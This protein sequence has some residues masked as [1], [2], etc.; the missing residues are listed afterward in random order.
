MK[1]TYFANKNG[2]QNQVRQYKKSRATGSDCIS[3]QLSADS[4]D[5]QGIYYVVFRRRT[6]VCRLY[7]R[8]RRVVADKFR[9]RGTICLL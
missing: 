7:D 2:W 3:S 6:V 8:F 9:I 4:I 1:V 5:R